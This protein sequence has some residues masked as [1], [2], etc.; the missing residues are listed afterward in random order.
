MPTAF[1]HALVGMGF[2]AF[3]VSSNRA[4]K[5]NVSTVLSMTAVSV[6]PDLDVI[7]F[8]LG[9]PYS[10]PLGHRGFFHSALFALFSACLFWWLCRKGSKKSSN[11]PLSVKILAI[12]ILVGLSHPLLDMLTD[13]GLG[14]AFFSPLSYERHFFPFQPI[15][16]SPIGLSKRVLPILWWETRLFLPGVLAAWAFACGIPKAISSPRRH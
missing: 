1:G 10:H 8:G 11:E 12:F 3:A 4:L 15:P 7:A 13:G 9:I 5:H 6:I 14:I 16:V 2:G